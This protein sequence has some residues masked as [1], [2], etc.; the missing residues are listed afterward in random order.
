M[1]P[2]ALNTPLVNVMRAAALK[3]ARAMVRD[4]TE[5]EQLQVSR[6]G[7]G[8]FVSTA[9]KR[10][11]QLLVRELG[12]ARPGFGF[13]AEEGGVHPASDGNAA[14]TKRWIIDPIDGTTNYLHGIPHFAISIAAEEEGKITAGLVYD[15]IKDDMFV[16]DRGNG[17]YLNDRRIRVS[18]RSRMPDSLFA[19]GIPFMDRGDHVL[20]NAQLA[21]VMA[22]SS[23][24]RRMGAASLDLAY[25][26][27][28][29]YEGFWES[30]LS[31][32]DL[33]AGILIVREAGGL[34][35]DYDG[36]DEVMTSGNV[37][38]G[39]QSL[40]GDLRTLV[41]PKNFKA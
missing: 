17:A 11:E 33:A 37:V 20:F 15:P 39:N 35:S 5:I 40:H 7:P 36:R 12:K 19:T 10:A 26:A 29:R 14:P 30:G 28:G 41:N 1:A 3:C 4:F 38:A 32:W 24:V 25:V 13:L 2:P 34:V 16:A 9:D 8:D 31:P 18:A 27:A 23:G 6:K 21:K 22:V